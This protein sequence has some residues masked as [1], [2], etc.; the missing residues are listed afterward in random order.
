MLPGKRGVLECDGPL[1]SEYPQG[2]VLFLG[3]VTVGGKGW[4]PV[5]PPS[6]RSYDIGWVPDNLTGGIR[7]GFLGQIRKADGRQPESVEA[8]PLHGSLAVALELHW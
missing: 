3:R 7:A 1:G 8:E 5:A 6:V 2:V 4:I